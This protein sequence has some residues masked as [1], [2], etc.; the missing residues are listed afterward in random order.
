MTM[1]RRVARRLRHEAS[2]RG[3]IPSEPGPAGIVPSLRDWTLAHRQHCGAR[4]ISSPAGVEPSLGE[5]R[6]V[7][8]VAAAAFEAAAAHIRTGPTMVADSLDVAVLPHGLVVGVDGIVMT[9]DALLAR[10]SAWDDEKL[11]ASGVPGSQRLPRAPMLS[12]EH[13]TVISQWCQAYYHWI[14]DA[15]PRLAVLEAAGRSDAAVVVPEELTDWQRRS[16]ELC[17][18]ADR[19]TPYSG[20]LRAELLLW[21]RPVALPGHTPRW[22]CNWIRER[23]VQKAGSDRRRR[24]YLTRRAKRDRRVANEADVWATLE[25]MGF[26]MIDAGALSLDQ[27]IDLF[28]DAAVVV[29]PHGGALTNILFAHRTLVV[30]LFEASYVNPC[31]YVLAERCDHDYWYLI[32]PPTPAGHVRVDVMQLVETLEAAGLDACGAR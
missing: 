17:G 32:G 1:G 27:Q 9:H 18:A 19:L 25:P 16:L 5:P 13:A 2:V 15:L 22:A 26:E 7:S 28:G 21:P 8:A 4:W 30:E 23:L 31:Y 29:S 10:E 14:T 6:T 3:L 11:Q 24:L 20:S 12:G